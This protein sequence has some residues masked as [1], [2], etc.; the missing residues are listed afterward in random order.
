MVGAN[1][2]TRARESI[3]A[4]HNCANPLYLLTWIVQKSILSYHIHTSQLHISN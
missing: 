1:N 4:S 2:N 3:K